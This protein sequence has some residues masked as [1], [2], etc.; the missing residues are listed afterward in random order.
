MPTSF[1]MSGMAVMAAMS[2]P[3]RPRS[4]NRAVMRLSDTGRK[5]TPA[6]SMGLRCALGKFFLPAA[7]TLGPGFRGRVTVFRRQL[8]KPFNHDPD[9][10]HDQP[11]GQQGHD[12]PN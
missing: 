11:A 6:G 10:H 1:R 12:L 4:I 7:V 2:R 3:V 9:N 5:A 8:A